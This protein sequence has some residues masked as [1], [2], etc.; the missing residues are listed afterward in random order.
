MVSSIVKH[1]TKEADLEHFWVP[2]MNNAG[3]IRKLDLI[4]RLGPTKSKIVMAIDH[5]FA[6]AVITEAGMPAL[7]FSVVSCIYEYFLHESCGVG[8]GLAHVRYKDWTVKNFDVFSRPASSK[9]VLKSVVFEVDLTGSELGRTLVDGTLR[10]SSDK[11]AYDKEALIAFMSKG[12]KV[13]SVV[14]VLSEKIG[15]SRE[16]METLLSC[17][18]LSSKPVK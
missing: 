16:N 9:T 6:V 1:L 17:V 4:Q 15:F 8:E 11:Q 13:S 2:L 14:S 10:F 3:M 12:N 18:S 5:L 7:A